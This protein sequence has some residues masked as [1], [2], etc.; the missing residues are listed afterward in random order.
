MYFQ[1]YHNPHDRYRKLMVMLQ[2]DVQNSL[3]IKHSVCITLNVFNYSVEEPP[4]ES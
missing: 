3:L 1:L 2:L 4:W